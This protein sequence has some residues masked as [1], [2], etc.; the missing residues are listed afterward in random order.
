VA[1]VEQHGRPFIARA[2][3]LAANT[4]QRGSDLVRMG[5]TD[6][7]TYDGQPGINVTQ[8]K[9]GLRIWIPL[10]PALRAAMETWER[11]PGPFLR[12]ADGTPLSRHRLSMAWER[13][14]D[15][16]PALRP[17]AG[18]V[19]HGLRATAVVRLRRAGAPATQIADMV[20]LSVAM[21]E[22]YCRFADQRDNALA[23]VHYLGRT[24]AERP[25]TGRGKVTR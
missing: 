3:T 16:N 14:R 20:G 5:P 7:E 8:K 15:V 24:G 23:A 22:R 11:Q 9:T 10:T 13:E 18:L 12:G 25:R 19:M 1:L 6:L 4:G 2:V 17:C 21:V